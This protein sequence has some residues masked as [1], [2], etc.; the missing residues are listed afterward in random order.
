MCDGIDGKA[1]DL[2]IV[3]YDGNWVSNDKQITYILSE[4]QISIPVHF[5]F[6]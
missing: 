3:N 2:N 1:K 6:F 5:K 4:D